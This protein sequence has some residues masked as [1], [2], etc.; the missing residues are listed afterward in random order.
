[1]AATSG[2]L[3]SW[4]NDP[5]PPL[6][7]F[8]VIYLCAHAC[9]G[10]SP[11]DIWDMVL[12]SPYPVWN[13]SRQPVQV[14]QLKGGAR[15]RF[16]PL[17]SR[18]S[19]TQRESTKGSSYGFC[20]FPF[21]FRSHITQPQTDQ[22]IRGAGK[23][24]CQLLSPVQLFTTPQT[25]AHQAPLSMGFSREE[26]WSGLPFPDSR[27]SS[28]PRDGKPL[29]LSHQGSLRAAGG[30]HRFSSHFPLFVVPVSLPPTQAH[31]RG[32]LNVMHLIPRGR[33]KEGRRDMHSKNSIYLSTFL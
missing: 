24:K 1:M 18:G 19:R 11:P 21:P 28:W 25:V 13:Q 2:R 23:W 27:R 10:L 7:A 22:E 16:P 30:F 8:C 5:S 17:C 20:S 15:D 26:Y 33:G 31:R 6:L 12:R 29:H 9:H 4:I 14:T 3:T 32:L